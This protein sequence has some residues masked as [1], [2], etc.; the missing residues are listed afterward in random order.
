MIGA[1]ALVGLNKI[2]PPRTLVLGVPGKIS[3]ELTATELKANQKN[4]KRVLRTI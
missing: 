1:G 4:V 2:I 3:R